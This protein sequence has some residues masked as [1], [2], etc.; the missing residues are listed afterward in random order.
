LQEATIDYEAAKAAYEEASAPA[1]QSELQDALSAIQTAQNELETLRNQPTAA[2]LASAEAQVA[3]AAA[4]LE[5][6][7]TG[8]TEAEL[9]EAQINLEQASLDLAAAQADLAEAQLVAPIDGTILSVE[10]SLGQEVS[11]GTTT[12]TMADLSQLKLTVNVAEV[13]VSKLQLGQA[14]EISLDALP[15]QT[16]SGVVTQIAPSS[17]SESGVVNYPVTIQ[18]AE[19]DLTGVRPGMTAVATLLDNDAAAGWLVPTSAM[20]EQDGT[21]QVLIVRDGQTQPVEVT[22]VSTQGEWTV[23]QSPELQ[24]GDEAAG[25]VSSFVDEADSSG[26][27]GPP[28]G[29]GGP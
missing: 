11:S 8:P 26:F 22:K 17:E 13:D 25:T 27:E 19:A 7:L 29:F 5:A 6:L 18:L 20:V 15:D 10:V 23:V 24:A 12:V 28:G 2:E 3:S 9:R 21:T 14:A 16:F 1:T 4:T